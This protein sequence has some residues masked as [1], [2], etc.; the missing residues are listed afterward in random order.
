[1]GTANRQVHKESYE[2]KCQLPCNSFSSEAEGLRRQGQGRET[3]RAECCHC[4]AVESDVLR[5][6]TTPLE[7]KLFL[8][9]ILL[10]CIGLWPH[11]ASAVVPFYTRTKPLN[12]ISLGS[13]CR[14]GDAEMGSSRMLA[15]GETKASGGEGRARTPERHSYRQ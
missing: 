3:R 15:Q 11:Q 8:Q 5:A 2:S 1:M 12:T 9:K 13:Q 6:K 10:G 14:D 4:W 7:W